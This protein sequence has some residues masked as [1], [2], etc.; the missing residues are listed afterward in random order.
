M[1]IWSLAAVGAVFSGKPGFILLA[2]RADQTAGGRA[3]DLQDHDCAIAE[4]KP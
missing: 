1:G 4:A 3:E 2:D